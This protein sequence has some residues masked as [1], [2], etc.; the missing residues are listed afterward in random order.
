[1]EAKNDVPD[2][3]RRFLCGAVLGVG[4]WAG[5]PLL[6]QASAEC[7]GQRC[8]RE[9]APEPLEAVLEPDLPIVDA[10]HHLWIHDREEMRR[11]FAAITQT[12]P[13]SK[14]VRVPGMYRYLY[15]D[16]LEDI[17]SGHNVRASI[18]LD[19][20]SMY[21]RGGPEPMRSVGEVEF[22][23][24]VAAMAESGNFGPARVCAG[25]ISDADLTV[26]EEVEEVLSEH[27]RAGGGR[28]RSVHLNANFDADP[29]LAGSAKPRLLYDER[30]R[31]GYK[32]LHVESST[33]LMG[34]SQ[35]PIAAEGHLYCT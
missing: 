13:I 1:M 34:S 17:Y 28:L 26:G 29:F 8:A 10:H 9:R 7:V 3:G 20:R 4:G 24:G 16:F 33:D 23:S 32:L 11:F 12:N 5:S 35:L 19:S 31:A 6:A 2:R 30:L 21:R 14:L 25:I 15:Q 18:F 27:T 22:A